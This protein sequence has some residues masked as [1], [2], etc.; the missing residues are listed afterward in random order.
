MGGRM[1]PADAIEAL[2][3]RLAKLSEASQRINENLAWTISWTRSW[4]APGC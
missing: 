2:R 3:E 4:P 1:Q